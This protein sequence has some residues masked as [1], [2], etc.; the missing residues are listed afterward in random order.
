VPDL[1]PQNSGS[2]SFGTPAMEQTHGSQVN[3]EGYCWTESNES[4]QIDSRPPES[5]LGHVSLSPGPFDRNEDESIPSWDRPVDLIRFPQ[6]VAS[7]SEQPYG[8]RTSQSSIVS[9]QF[10]PA[11]NGFDHPIPASYNS[12]PFST[13]Y[14]PGPG[15]HLNFPSAPTHSQ[16]FPLAPTPP[17]Y[18][19][20][21][22]LHFDQSHGAPE[23]NV[24]Y[25][26]PYHERQAA[27]NW[28][29]DQTY[30]SAGINPASYGH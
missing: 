6:P 9:N 13:N 1:A 22:P 4:L 25:D 14:G 8:N 12:F 18:H 21:P 11:N 26:A 17:F 23:G 28:P 10:A 5:E 16:S 30:P 3:L 24:P 15:N 29:W 7:V 2:A 27:A 19:A 20:P